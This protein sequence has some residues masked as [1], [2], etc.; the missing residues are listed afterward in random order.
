MTRLNSFCSFLC[1][2]YFFSAFVVISQVA[3]AAGVAGD[4]QMREVMLQNFVNTIEHNIALNEQNLQNNAPVLSSF[5]SVS[6]PTIPI[7][8]YTRRIVSYSN[9]SIAA[10]ILAL[11]Y[12]A[13][14]VNGHPEFTLSRTSAHR[15]VLTAFRLSTKFA[16]DFH[17]NNATFGQI[18]GVSPDE[19]NRLEL[20]LL[21]A[22][23]F[24]LG[25]LPHDAS[26]H[27]AINPN[28]EEGDR[29]LPQNDL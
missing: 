29:C 6:P 21:G 17:L 10:I 27:E 4:E 24:D 20:E 5:H 12:I 22:I 2:L 1:G 13:R 14:F 9:C 8:D 18:G 3:T 28:C 15:L 16:D 23:N 26:N 19:M 11:E 7:A 25:L